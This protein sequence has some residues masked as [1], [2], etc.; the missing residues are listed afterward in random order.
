MMSHEPTGRAVHGQAGDTTGQVDTG[1]RVH[2]VHTPAASV[3]TH[4]EG[5]AMDASVKAWA[6][7]PMV[8]PWDSWWDGYWRRKRRPRCGEI[9]GN[10]GR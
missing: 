3:G 5:T 9:G 4:P 8:L 2:E 10:D 7:D 6:H 1:D